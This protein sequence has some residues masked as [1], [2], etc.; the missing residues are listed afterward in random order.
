MNYNEW[1]K[2][3]LKDWKDD[4]KNIYPLLKELADSKS[5]KLAKWVF[6]FDFFAKKINYTYFLEIIIFKKNKN[7]IS[8]ERNWQVTKNKSL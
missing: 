5:I 6:F 3:V 4:G 2:R 8:W 7:I 1:T